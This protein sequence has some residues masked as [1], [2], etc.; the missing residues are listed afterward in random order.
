[1]PSPLFRQQ[2]V[3]AKRGSWLGRIRVAQPVQLWA[4]SAFAAL[5]AVAVGVFLALGS[6]AHRTHVNGQLVPVQGMATVLTP[7]TGVLTRM[8]VPEGGY[9]KAGQTLALVNVPRATVAAG[10]ILVALETRLQH[11][12]DGLRATHAARQAQFEAQT[13][14]LRSQLQTARHELT[15]IEGEISTQHEQIRIAEDM[16][17]RLKELESSHY[18]SQL[19]IKQQESAALAQRSQL[20]ALQRQ[21][22]SIQRTIVQ[23]EQILAELPSQRQASEADFQHDLAQLEQERVEILSQGELAVTAP[24]DGM[25]AAWLYKP[26]QAVPAGQPLL[27]L[28]PGDGALEAELLVPSR[29]I[30][31]IDPGDTVLLRYHAYPYQKFGHQQGRVSRISRSAVNSAIGG[32]AT[33]AESFYR[34]SVSLDQQAIMAYGKPEP[35]KPGMAL[36]AD[37]LG[38]R[39]SLIEWILEPLYSIQ[40][41]VFG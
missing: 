18:A 24:T 22:A 15:Q 32:S 21:A 3:D 41:T 12:A 17:A 28:V 13:S 7:V 11:R 30:G 40:G 23:I 9:V 5:A 37:I 19:Q 20:Q 10:D 27:T 33:L 16:L 39:R 29:A 36:D 1:M 26:G 35:L 6:Y 25:V 2:A 34:I 31:F 38:E 8:D 4:L 14:G